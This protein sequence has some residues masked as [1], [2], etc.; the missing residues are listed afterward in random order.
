VPERGFRSGTS[1]ALW[2]ITGC[3]NEFGAAM[4]HHLRKKRRFPVRKIPFFMQYAPTS[5]QTLQEK[6]R[7]LKPG[8]KVWLQVVRD[9]QGRDWLLYAQHVVSY[10]PNVVQ[11]A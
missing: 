7:F 10:A 11:A 3:E 2:L 8:K 1:Y 4:R 6:C 5:L 9:E